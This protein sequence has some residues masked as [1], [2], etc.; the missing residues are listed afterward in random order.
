MTT[1]EILLSREYATIGADRELR[2][3]AASGELSRVVRGAFV[4]S[5][6]WNELDAE[7]RYRITVLAAARINPRTVFSHDSA[8]ALW[9]LPFFGPTPTRLHSVTDRASGGRSISGLTRHAIGSDASATTIDDALVTSLP[10]TLADVSCLPGFT[11]AV[12]MV[13]Y[14]LRGARGAAAEVSDVTAELTALGKVPG[15]AR[16]A[17]VIEFAN[18]LSGSVGE[19]LSRVQFLVLRMPAPELQVPFYD[20][21]GLI[22]VV[23]FYWRGLGLVGEFDGGVKYGQARAYKR[24]VSTAQLVEIERERER[25][26]R[27]VVANVARW[28]WSV[29]MDR[30]RLAAR[31][32]EF[33]LG[34]SR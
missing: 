30:R 2:A 13:D 12:V 17:R 20:D 6:Q 34:A 24:D 32:A 4:T 8:A 1:P 28:N 23:D 16:A 19:S 25:R 15:H 33:G 27:R 5:A 26:L 11:R 10:R 21:D 7:G 9:G 14:G 3:R 22:G 31:L 29:A 18:P